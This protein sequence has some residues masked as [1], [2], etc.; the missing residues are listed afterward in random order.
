MRNLAPNTFPQTWIIFTQ[1]CQNSGKFNINRKHWLKV[2]ACVVCALSHVYTACH[3][4]TDKC[5]TTN[6][7]LHQ[8]ALHSLKIL[9]L[10]NY[11]ISTMPIAKAER[12]IMNFDPTTKLVLV[13]DNHRVIFCG[14]RVIHGPVH[15]TRALTY[16]CLWI[17]SR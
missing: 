4:T 5:D 7:K 9:N 13:R 12:W 3:E 1:N 16:I 8:R 10:S 17:S 2:W 6:T 15:T 14:N 11:K